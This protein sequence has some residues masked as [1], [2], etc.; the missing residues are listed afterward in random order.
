MCGGISGTTSTQGGSAWEDSSISE[1]N[2][3]LIRAGHFQLADRSPKQ[4]VCTQLREGKG[5]GQRATYQPHKRPSSSGGILGVVCKWSEPKKKAKYAPPPVLH[6][7]CWSS[8]LWG[9]CV[10]FAVWFETKLRPKLCGILSE[11]FRRNIGNYKQT[12]R[13]NFVLRKSRS[14]LRFG[15]QGFPK[16]CVDLAVWKGCRLMERNSST[17]THSGLL[18]ATQAEKAL[19]ADMG[20]GTV[21]KSGAHRSKMSCT[22]RP[23]L[24]HLHTENNFNVTIMSCIAESIRFRTC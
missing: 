3:Q 16:W 7:R 18:A 13:A 17:S 9:W 2:C 14:N 20:W 5:M 6:S 8:I 15:L 22:G 12:L 10:D 11:H 19:W 24:L 4:A 1:H 21:A 23:E